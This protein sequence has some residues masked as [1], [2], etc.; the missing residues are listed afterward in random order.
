MNT[1]TTPALHKATRFD[2][3][4]NWV[5]GPVNVGGEY[6]SAD[7]WNQTTKVPEDKSDGYSSWLQFT[8]AKDFML[9]GRYDSSNPSKDL[10]PALKYTYYNL[11][12][13]WKANKAVTGSL[14]YKYGVAEGGTVSTGNGTI[15]STR[16]GYEGKYN[17]IGLWFSF[18][19]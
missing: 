17:E 11:G 19:F 4:A 8:V 18:D 3:L 12:L 10:K 16:A 13:Q 9:F 7:N 6:F 15:G 14:T 2:A 5:I 1:D